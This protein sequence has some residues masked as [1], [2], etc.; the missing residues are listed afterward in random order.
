MPWRNFLSKSVVAQDKV[1]RDRDG[2]LAG[3]LA[4]RPTLTVDDGRA[5]VTSVAV[6]PH[7]IQ[8]LD[9]RLYVGGVPASVHLDRTVTPVHSSLAGGC[10]VIVVNG[11]SVAVSQ[12]R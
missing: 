4:C 3:W 9:G 12:H 10:S 5:H 2:P 11:R 6:T 7:Q 8:P 1:S